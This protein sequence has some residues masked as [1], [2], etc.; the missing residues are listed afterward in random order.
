MSPHVAVIDPGM[1]VA[2]LDCFNRMVLRS[3]IPLTY[4]LP[5]LFGLD[6]LRRVE[7]ELRGV[8]IFGSGASV[9]DDLPWQHELV[10]WLAPRVRSGM[11]A[12]GLCYGHQ[13]LATLLGGEVGYLHP[14]RRKEVGHR[15]V[16]LRATA[17][18]DAGAPELVVSHREAVVR[19]PDGVDVV[20]STEV[21]AVEAF[22]HR[23]LPVFGVQAHPEAT[24]AFLHNNQV[25]WD[26]TSAE[27]AG[28]HALVDGFLS[29][30]VAGRGTRA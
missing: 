22:A 2:E 6:S 17:A 16:P 24:P 25:P 20:G 1:R 11:P 27:L 30:V 28:G 13:L 3:P 26:T 19:V 12:L 4:H 7:S 9:H 8:V 14:D 23:T 10:A 15:R 5:A 29:R 21:C 18:W